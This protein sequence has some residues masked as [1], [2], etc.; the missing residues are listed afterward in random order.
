MIVVDTGVIARAPVRTL[1]AGYTATKKS[2][3]QN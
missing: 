1:V 3:S 2:V